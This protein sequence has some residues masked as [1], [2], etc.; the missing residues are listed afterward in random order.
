MSFKD[1]A[2][3]TITDMVRFEV[4]SRWPSLSTIDY[5]LKYCRDARREMKRGLRRDSILECGVMYY[6][7]S[8]MAVAANSA[9]KRP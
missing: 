8:H 6:L 2:T 9:A 3:G 7:V 1:F 4:N 5:A